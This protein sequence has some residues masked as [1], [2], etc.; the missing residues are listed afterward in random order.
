MNKR[1]VLL[2]A[3]L[4][5]SGPASAADVVV[6]VNTLATAPTREQLADIYLGRSRAFTPLDQSESRPI[7]V[8]FYQKATGRDLAQVKAAWSRIVFAGRGVA[9]REMASAA[10]M[11]AAVAAD[12]K[13]IGYIDKADL[14]ASVKVALTLN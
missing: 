1:I 5:V 7:Y 14:D 6:I 4:I 9:P 13:A 10:A 12:P 8:E 2:L 3:A 11:K